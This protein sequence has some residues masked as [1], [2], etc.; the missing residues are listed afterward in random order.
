[1]SGHML[2][3]QGAFDADQSELRA[4][5]AGKA[6]IAMSSLDERMSGEAM[7]EGDAETDHTPFR[8]PSWEKENA[9]VTKLVGQALDVVGERQRLLGDLYPFNVDRLGLEY[10]PSDLGVYEFCLATCDAVSNATRRYRRL[11]RHFERVVTKL[12][13]AFC[14]A[15][16]L[17][18]RFGWPSERYFESMP[19]D[20][21][22]RIAMMKRKCRFDDDEWIASHSRHVTKLIRN[23]KDSKID[24][25]VRRSL[26]DD[27]PGALTILGQCGCGKHDVSDASSK[28]TELS[29][30]WLDLFF[31]QVTVPRPLFVFATSQH[32]ACPSQMHIKQATSQALL[33]DRIRLV[34]LAAAQSGCLADV[35]IHMKSLTDFVKNN[36][37][38]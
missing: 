26:L 12:L 22:G 27:R 21:E 28:H 32:I 1:M 8:V 23:A 30:N 36:P 7:D 34:R 5:R 31:S 35:E 16:A 37:P 33:F 2:D 11:V 3:E 19:T 17:G 15:D 4:M 29:Y 10:E 38:T 20:I 18:C 9:G 6:S 14:G 25:V 24:I 13:T